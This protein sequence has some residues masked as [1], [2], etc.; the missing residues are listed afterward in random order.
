MHDEFYMK[1]FTLFTFSA[2]NSA[3]CKSKLE[4]NLDC[5]LFAS[6]QFWCIPF[7]LLCAKWIGSIDIIAKLVTLQFTHKTKKLFISRRPKTWKVSTVWVS[8]E[9][10]QKRKKSSQKLQKLL[11][12]FDTRLKQTNNNSLSL[13]LS[14]STFSVC[15]AHHNQLIH[16]FRS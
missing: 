3:R 14:L 10:G 12:Q 15:L 4:S 8:N 16:H 2:W 6:S 1:V 7:V 5:I 11:I 13:S 9:F